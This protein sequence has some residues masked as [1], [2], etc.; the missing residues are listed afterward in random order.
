LKESQLKTD[1]Q[2]LELKEYHDQT[3]DLLR[4]TIKDFRV[5]QKALGDLGL[6]QGE[7]AED[8]FYRNVKGLFSPLDLQFERIRQNEKVKGRGEYD[9]VADD[10]IRQ[11]A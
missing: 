1:A 10:K 2:I 11:H 8:L 9:I 6:V 7:V 3:E 4:E 5:T